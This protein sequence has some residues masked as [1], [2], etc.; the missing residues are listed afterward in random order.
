VIVLARSSNE[1]KIENKLKKMH[2]NLDI[3]IN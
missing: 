2:F 3:H 1:K